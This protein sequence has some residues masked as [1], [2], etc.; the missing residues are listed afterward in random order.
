[1]ASATLQTL[2]TA[3]G[4]G[5]ATWTDVVQAVAAAGAVLA[6]IAIPLTAY[7]RRPRLSIA[8]D[9][10]RVQNKV[11]GDGLPYLRL[12]VRNT[13]GR[14]TA[15]ETRVLVDRYQENRGGASAVT[16]GSPELAWPS[17]GAAVDGVVVFAN[18][19]RPVSLGYLIPAYRDQ[20]D[21]MLLAPDEDRAAAI[22]KGA[23][24][25]LRLHLAHNLF[26]VDEREY[27]KP[28]D[29]GY[30]VRLVI[31]AEDGA[32]RSFDVHVNWE[33]DARDAQVALESV[34]IEVVRA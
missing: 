1:M 18:G 26:L 15:K 14:R 3:N 25:H 7:A 17:T 28:V 11:E 10:E 30:T 8:E 20:Y 19:K 16:M 4:G 9:K 13:R 6:V 23:R 29:G 21:E 24:W 5:G 22:F 34:Q 32:A 27:L 12:L 33:G 2:C 31:G